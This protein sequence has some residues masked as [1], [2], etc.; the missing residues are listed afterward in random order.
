M[1]VGIIGSPDTVSLVNTTTW[2]QV[3]QLFRRVFIVGMFLLFPG[4]ISAGEGTI[5]IQGAF[6]AMIEDATAGVTFNERGGVWMLQLRSPR[7]YKKAQGVGFTVNIFFSKTF[8]PS[9]GTFPVL[10]SYRSNPMGLG[11]SVLVSGNDRGT[12]SHDTVGEVTFSSFDDLVEGSF[13]F[14]SFD[15]SDEPR[16]K[17]QAG[18]VFSCSRGEAL[19]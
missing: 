12:F 9:E 4:F 2:R 15:G 5:E 11:G 13:A 18:G 7:E 10:F 3:I 17:I 1:G 19:K 16:R 6:E 8:T 14:E